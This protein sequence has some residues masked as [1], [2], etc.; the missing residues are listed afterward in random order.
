M[1]AEGL[2]LDGQ[3]VLLPEDLQEGEQHQGI[4]LQILNDIGIV[5]NF[6]DFYVTLLGKVLEYL[7]SDLLF[8]LFANRAH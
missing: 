6:A 4:P 1:F 8:G 5:S 2:E 7:L 3:S